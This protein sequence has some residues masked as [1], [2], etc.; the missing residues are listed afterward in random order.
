MSHKTSFYYQIKFF[1]GCGF[2]V[3]APDFP[4]FGSSA[5]ITEAWSVG[6]YARWLK[7]FIVASGIEDA[8]IIAHSFGARVALKLLSEESFPGRLIIVGGAGLVKPR[9]RAYMRR[10]KTYRMVKK[11]APAFAEKHFGSREYR[12][13][14]PV[15]RQSY[16]KIVNEDLSNCALHLHNKT[17]LV[18]GEDDAVTPAEEEGRT[19]NK[20]I[21]DS[22]L[23]IMRGDHFCFCRYPELFNAAALAFLTED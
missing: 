16:K 12:A 22:K 6:D 9:S 10:V 17:L 23:F 7:Q 1:S 20:L 13:L 5:P 4:G 19:F 18:Y 15:M 11:F 2:A 8:H 14:S 21:A 3:T